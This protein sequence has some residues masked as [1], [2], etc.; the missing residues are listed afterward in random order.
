ML[1]AAAS[2]LPTQAGTHHRADALAS[3]GVVHC[4]LG[5]EIWRQ[6]ALCAAHT[7]HVHHLVAR[8]TLRWLAAWPAAA[9]LVRAAAA[10]TARWRPL[11]KGGHLAEA[12]AERVLSGR[13]EKPRPRP[14]HLVSGDVGELGLIIISGV[15]LFLAPELRFTAGVWSPGGVYMYMTCAHMYMYMY[16]CSRALES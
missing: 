6:G 9:A 10:A 4:I 1:H 5:A 11:L 2:P 3:C 13:L 7:W 8:R 15:V 14:L 12:V 16:N